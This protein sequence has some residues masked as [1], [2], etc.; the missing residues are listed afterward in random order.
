MNF[1]LKIYF[2]AEFISTIKWNGPAYYTQTHFDNIDISDGIILIAGQRNSSIDLKRILFNTTSTLYLQIIKAL[3]FYYL[4]SGSP[5]TLYKMELSSDTGPTEIETDFLQPFK[6]K[7]E[8]HQIMTM[9]QMQKLF[10]FQ[11]K[12]LLFLTGLTYY[13]EAAQDNNFDLYWRSFNSLYNIISRSNK[14]FDGL[15]AIRQF[16]KN[17]R[18]NFSNTLAYIASDTAEDIRKL[19][20]RDYILNN[21]PSTNFKQTKSFAETIKRFSDMRIISVFKATLSYRIDALKNH[22]LDGDVNRHIAQC[23]TANQTDDVEL[24]CF[25]V[26][27]Y[28]YFIRN[29]YFHAEKAHPLFILK[30][31][32][33]IEEMERISGVF[34]HFLADL[35]RCNILY[36]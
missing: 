1:I 21:W 30:K 10:L 3:S 22:G 26:L 32:S 28:S 31:T 25:Y 7:L 14:D 27:K 24:L 16:V 29:K 11:G 13:I 2:N 17:N 18:I 33:E 23:Q 4:C 20:I 9:P 5:I 15:C 12:E 36:L 34:E 8:T 35:I 6:K 19:R